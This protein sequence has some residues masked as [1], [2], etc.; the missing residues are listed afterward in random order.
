MTTF[1]CVLAIVVIVSLQACAEPAPI[2]HPPV[3]VQ[4]P[5]LLPGAVVQGASTR[6]Y[7]ASYSPPRYGDPVP[8]EM[9]AYCL[10]R[11]T[12]RRGRYVRAGI[13]AADP[14]L[15]PLSRYVE[16]YDGR[17]YLGRFLI[18]DTGRL[19]KGNIVDVWMPTCREA[20]IFGRR[21]GIAVLVP[22]EPAVSLAGSPRP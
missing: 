9:T 13:V 18:D 17:R 12:T 4:S 19:I 3:I 7:L 16:L 14:R 8:V 2:I 21:K 15:F 20:K 6:W 5:V 22:R 10:T 11:T 1:R